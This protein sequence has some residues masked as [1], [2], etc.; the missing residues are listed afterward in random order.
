MGREKKEMIDKAGGLVVQ[1]DDTA[2]RC[3]GSRLQICHFTARVKHS[4]PLVD[5][6]VLF[7]YAPV[8]NCTL[9]QTCDSHRRIKPE[10][11]SAVTWGGGHAS[12]G[13]R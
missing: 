2:K 1:S 8:M 9:Y 6:L 3:S 4:P 5:W 12:A 11:R 13:W 7:Y 10:V